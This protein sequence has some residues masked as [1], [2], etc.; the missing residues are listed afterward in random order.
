MSDDFDITKIM[1]MMEMAKSLS[2]QASQELPPTEAAA[3]PQPRIKALTAA[4]P[5]MPLKNQRALAISIKMLEIQEINRHYDAIEA[6]AAPDPNWRRK[7]IAAI[8]P[9]L[10]DK[11]QRGLRSI[12]QMMEMQEMIANIE[13][14]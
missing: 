11:K 8:L 10:D 7:T 13:K 1:Q 4:L 6:Q 12:V 14:F 2:S 3:T 5:H 9:H